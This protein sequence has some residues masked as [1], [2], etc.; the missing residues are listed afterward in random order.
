[1]KH[2]R[3]SL[4]VQVT[5][6]MRIWPW[7]YNPA[8]A[9]PAGTACPLADSVQHGS[10]ALLKV[11]WVLYGHWNSE[12]AAVGRQTHCNSCE[13]VTCSSTS[14][15]AGVWTTKLLINFARI[16]FLSL[17]FLEKGS[18]YT[19]C[20]LILHSTE[21]RSDTYK[22]CRQC[23]K[24]DEKKKKSPFKHHIG[25]CSFTSSILSPDFLS[26][27]LTWPRFFITLRSNDNI[28]IFF[29]MADNPR[30]FLYLFT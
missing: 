10:S 26:L 17:S 23:L 25:N 27:H 1:M 28:V 29:P 2:W 7:R 18:S 22:L 5:R 16:C 6:G 15:Y 19:F 14:Q 24:K 12:N 13:L 21:I 4:N 11:Q 30:P 3:S 8:S 9:C 20:C